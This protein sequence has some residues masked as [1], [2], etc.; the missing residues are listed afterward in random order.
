MVVVIA[1]IISLILQV[2]PLAAAGELGVLRGEEAST[3]AALGSS[4]SGLA[5]AITTLLSSILLSGML[6][7]I[8]GRAVFGAGITIG[9]A[10]QRVRGRV[11]ALIGYTLLWFFG[12]IVLIAVFVLVVVAVAE[13]SGGAA[14]VLA[15]PLGLG[16]IA[17]LVYLWTVLSFAPPLIVLERLGVF[18][19]VARS[20]RLVKG[21]FWRVL[22]IRLLATIVASI[23]AGAVSIPFS[24]T[25][26]ILLLSSESVTTILI[27]LAL[28]AIGGAVGQVITA[29]F[30]AGAVVL[31]YTDR[32][33]RAE[34][35][36]LVL[37]TG[38]A[39]AP[40]A[41]P[42]STDHLWL[43]RQP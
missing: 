27:A 26:Q 19:A 38:A 43:T 34:A 31:L 32:R 37:Q 12:V 23:V 28:V 11:L 13:V 1:Q 15:V 42:D 40:G 2:G 4:A 9:E 18:Q 22:G 10:W 33:I 7:V 25:G 17:L 21:D 16:L 36:D 5:G 3:A 14:F 24:L 30:R 6:T 20:V 35:F 8:V 39:I 29:P 41:A